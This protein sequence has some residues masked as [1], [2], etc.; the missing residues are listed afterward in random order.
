MASGKD[1]NI[2]VARITD[3]FGVKGQVKIRSFTEDSQ[4]LLEFSNWIVS[5]PKLGERS[6][7]VVAA[8]FQSSHIIA[9]LQGLDNRE[10][11]LELKGSD[12]LIPLSELPQLPPGTYY[13]NELIGLTVS[14]T[15]GKNFG[16]VME[17]IA[18]GAND[19]LV[20]NGHKKHLIP[21][22]DSVIVD[23]DL[24]KGTMRVDWFEDF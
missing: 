6:F 11:A 4:T 23:V 8:K 20:V 21:Y 15:D 19:V 14:N 3:A 5:N 2:V 9:A 24:D 1:R 17:I 7:E 16:T 13:W 10:E 12:I 18:T 22:L